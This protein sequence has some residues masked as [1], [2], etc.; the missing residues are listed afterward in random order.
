MPKRL[1]ANPRV[2]IIETP[3]RKSRGA[4]SLTRACQRRNFSR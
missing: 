2:L 1:M 3:Y 4:T